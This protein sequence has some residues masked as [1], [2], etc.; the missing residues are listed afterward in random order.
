MLEKNKDYVEFTLQTMMATHGPYQDDTEVSMTGVIN[1]YRGLPGCL[2]IPCDVVVISKRYFDRLQT[3]NEELKKKLGEF[4]FMGWMESAKLWKKKYDDIF[5][6]IGFSSDEELHDYLANDAKCD[7][8]R[9]AIASLEHNVKFARDEHRDLSK[10]LDECEKDYISERDKVTALQIENEQLKK[11]LQVPDPFAEYKELFEKLHSKEDIEKFEWTLNHI[12]GGQ[13]SANGWMVTAKLWRRN[14]ETL[15]KLVGFSSTEEIQDYLTNEA[16]CD[17]LQEAVSKL[18][19]QVKY[20]C[21]DWQKVTGFSTPEKCSSYIDRLEK[22]LEDIK[23][24][25]EED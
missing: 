20:T 15:S 1:G 24:L 21:D 16:E 19:D 11:K 5:K 4:D 3:E 18:K 6:L 17:T 13:A 22:K 10:K 23:N 12:C 8:L 7:T 2:D 14:Y 25:T 9:E